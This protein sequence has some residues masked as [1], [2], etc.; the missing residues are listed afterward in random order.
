ME[1][2]L[3]VSQTLRR[4]R[5]S[6][7]LMMLTAACVVMLG[8]FPGLGNAA[9]IDTVVVRPSIGP[10]GQ[11]VPPPFVPSPSFGGYAANALTSLEGDM[12]SPV[13]SDPTVDPIGY[14]V[15]NAI[16]PDLLIH[17]QPLLNS[18]MG[19]AGPAFPFDGEFGHA[20]YFGLHVVKDAGFKMKNITFEMDSTD[21]FDIFD[22]GPAAILAG[23]DFSTTRVGI[24]YGA[25]GMKGGGDDI[26]YSSDVLAMT[27]DDI[28]IN[29][30]NIVGFA[31]TIRDVN[32]G[33]D[34]ATQA[35]LNTAVGTVGSL[36][37][38]TITGEY[39]VTPE[40]GPAMS[41][42]A[43]VSIIPEPSTFVLFGLGL[44][45][46]WVAARRRSRKK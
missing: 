16:S 18:W 8:L 35:G 43:S 2:I 30:L 21:A 29:E 9:V 19:V 14:K 40:S 39:I 26:T 45:G 12:G 5:P 23:A 28:V 1:Q 10:V 24:D 11:V 22:F 36:N 46:L 37:P 27:D 4:R 17:T 7:M 20:L 34:G 42:S 38:F 31:A 13:G 44:A 3:T 6:R 41:G 25:N 15:F 33:G 32:A